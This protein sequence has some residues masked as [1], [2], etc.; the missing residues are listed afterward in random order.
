MKENRAEFH[1]EKMAE[2]L[3]VSR[4]GYH[5]WDHRKPSKRTEEGQEILKDILELYWASHC[6]YGSR[7][8]TK[9]INKRRELPVNHKRIARLMHEYGI[10]SKV[11]RRFVVTTESKH[12][13]PMAANS[14]QR[15]FVAAAKN[16]KWVSDTTY[17]WTRE[18]W[19][20]IAGIMDLYGR[21]SIGLSVST[22]N[23]E[24]LVL[25]ALE[26]A[27]NRAGKRNVV[28]CILH[29]DRGSTYCS[30]EYQKRMKKYGIQCSMSRKGD[31]WDNAPMESFWGKMK[32]EWFETYCQTREEA[33]F[34]VHEYVWSFYNRERPHAS[35]GYLTP[36]EYYSK[37]QTA[38]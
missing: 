9:E 31:C 16:E 3:G 32:M 18:G 21:K 33:I 7:K 5:D 4:S 35:N 13:K 24:S 37:P 23:D 1:V 11:S 36:E 28:N 14:L 8:I 25:E 22:R 34:K 15:N 2:V 30:D 17:L 38:A 27:R 19:L 12:Q 29:S 6:V 10:Y 20:Y 26:D